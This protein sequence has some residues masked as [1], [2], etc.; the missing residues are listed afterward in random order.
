MS[1]SDDA[2]VEELFN[3]AKHKVEEDN[4]SPEVKP[5]REGERKRLKKH[6]KDKKKKKKRHLDYD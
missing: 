4:I 1:D 5:E 3:E 2:E 6:K